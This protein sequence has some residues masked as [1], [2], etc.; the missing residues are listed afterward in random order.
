V[1]ADATPTSP[2]PDST[3]PDTGSK[4][5]VTT[6]ETPASR[7]RG[8]KRLALVLSTL[9]LALVA[10]TVGFAVAGQQMTLSL[11]GRAT[12]IRS[13]GD[14]V[15]EVLRDQGVKVGDHDVVVPSLDSKVRSGSRIAVRF[16]RPLQVNLDGQKSS[17]WVTATDVAS[18]VEQIGLRLGDARL[19]TSR[20][21]PIGRDGM[22]LQVVTPK[23]L[24]L[25]LFGRK[26]VKKTITAL[27]V[28]QALNQ[29]GLHV[30]GDDLVRPSRGRLLHDGDKI[31]FDRVIT[32]TKRVNDERIGFTTITRPDSSMEKGDTKVVR[33]GR[34]GSRDV[35]YRLRL[36]NGHVKA[37]K[38]LRVSDRRAPLAAIVAV[39]TKEPAPAV[40][41]FASGST[42]WDRIAQCES[43]G[44]WAINTGNGYYGGLQFNLSTWHSYGGS[45][46]PNQNSRE[47]QIAVAERVRAATGG[48]GSWPGCASKL[49]LL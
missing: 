42:V 30:D 28:A 8:R 20:S 21:A 19:S 15:A 23:T 6:A 13:S 26:P 7:H 33:A 17:H 3:T 41:A 38:E 35:V 24:S 37:R 36:V 11:D 34:A 1:A 18:A 40:V 44:N 47:A 10:T 31:V 45:G 39:G 25:E 48:Y 2:T 29:L 27:T 49:G 14:T 46:Y 4:L 22:A 12:E 43:G 9:T 32:Q 16:G 5:V